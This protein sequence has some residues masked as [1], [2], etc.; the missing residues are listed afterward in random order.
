MNRRWLWVALPVFAVFVAVENYLFFAGS[1]ARLQEVP[2]DADEVLE[3]EFDE[4]EAEPLE[5]L[6]ESDLVQWLAGIPLDR[7]PFWRSD[8][9]SAGLAAPGLRGNGLRLAGTL[10]GATRKVAWI[11]GAPRSVGDLVADQR[12]VDI[13]ADGVV[14][15]RD[16]EPVFLAIA[17]PAGEVPA[18]ADLDLAE[19]HE[20]ADLRDP[21]ESED[22]AYDD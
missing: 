11:G 15:E 18:N 6:D 7:N 4:E 20:G 8:E 3:V 22:D 19:E 21:E 12:I 14:L 16:G 5:A 10:V 1:G 9:L 17:S 13:R 2:D